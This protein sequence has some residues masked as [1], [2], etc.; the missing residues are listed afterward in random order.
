MPWNEGS[1][2][3]LENQ[4]GLEGAPQTLGDLMGVVERV[5]APEEVMALRSLPY[6][7]WRASVRSS[8]PSTLH[9]EAELSR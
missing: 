1:N 3:R 5:G 6:P 8:T 9:L 2:K 7:A 4:E